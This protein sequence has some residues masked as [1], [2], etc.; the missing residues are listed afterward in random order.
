MAMFYFYGNTGIWENDIEWTEL[1]NWWLDNTF[2]TPATSL[3]TSSD[4]VI[5][6]STIGS[7]NSGEPTV[8]NFTVDNAG[9][10]MNITVTGTATFNN[11][12][13][14]N[15]NIHG[16]T[17]FNNNSYNEYGNITGDVTFN[18]SSYNGYNGT[19]NGNATFNGSSVC[20]GSVNGHAVFNGTS[21]VGYPNNLFGT[22]DS[23]TFNDYSVAKDIFLSGAS[24]TITF[25]DYA[26]CDPDSDLNFGNC[27]IVFND[28]SSVS[29]SYIR[30]GEGSNY[31]L[32]VENSATITFNDNSMYWVDET[33][34]DNG[35][36]TFRNNAVNNSQTNGVN[37]ATFLPNRGINGS[38]ILGIL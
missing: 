34:N 22:L 21:Y 2:T 23:L 33:Y 1:G 19:I 20:N 17:I 7:S 36:W 12:S 5:A 4:S 3:P 32:Q 28:Y 27:T 6:S 11:G 26:V 8:V 35:Q 13:Q 9:L 38:S 10:E 30:R 16:N 15:G 37:G 29:D 31:R 14:N 25:N 18:D 24:I